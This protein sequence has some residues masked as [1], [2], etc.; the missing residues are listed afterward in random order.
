MRDVAF[1]EKRTSGAGPADNVDAT[2]DG[3]WYAVKRA[4]W[5]IPRDG[6]FCGAGLRSSGFRVQMHKGIEFGLKGFN[7]AEMGVDDFY[8]RNFLG[9]DACCDFR[10]RGEGRRVSHKRKCESIRA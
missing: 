6:S 8:R 4:E 10:D 9:A 3:D 2:F 5:L 1:A 7:A